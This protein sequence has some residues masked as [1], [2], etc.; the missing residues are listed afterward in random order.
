VN[1][2]K[3]SNF[4]GEVSSYLVV[5]PAGWLEVLVPSQ[6]TTNMLGVDMGRRE[7]LVVEVRLIICEDLS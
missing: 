3:A 7:A 1:L 4:D 6:D 5:E 2:K